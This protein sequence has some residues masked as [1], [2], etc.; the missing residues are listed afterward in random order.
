[1]CGSEV[2][3]ALRPV[4]RIGRGDGRGRRQLRDGDVI[5]VPVRTIRR[6]G[7]QDMRARPADVFDNRRDGFGD[8]RAI[9]LLIV[10]IEQADLPDA[11]R[12]GRRMELA[13]ANLRQRCAAWMLRAVDA[14]A[15]VPPVFSAR[16][17]EQEGLDPF[18]RISREYAAEPERFVVGMSGHDHQPQSSGHFV[19]EDRTRMAGASHPRF[20][21]FSMSMANGRN[22]P[23]YRTSA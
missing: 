11:E 8:V 7:E 9:E 15:E 14:V 20:G 17:G 1:M 22:G 5:G 6:E 4:L 10:I 3:T 13:F 16:G 18:A 2:S 12:G 21:S 19:S 23:A